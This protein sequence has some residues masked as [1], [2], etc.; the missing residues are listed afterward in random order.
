[1]HTSEVGRAAKLV[2]KRDRLLR[3][4]EAI[5]KPDSQEIKLRYWLKGTCYNLSASSS[6]TLLLQQAMLVEM[7][8]QICE[9]EMNLALLGVVDEEGEIDV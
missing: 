5:R 9:V 6:I 4:I 1:M 3:Y 8:S 2:E 7:R